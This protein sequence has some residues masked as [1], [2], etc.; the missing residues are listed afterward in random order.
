MTG[1]VPVRKEKAGSREASVITKDRRFGKNIA[2]AN[3]YM[4]IFK[5]MRGCIA[6][7]VFTHMHMHAHTGKR[8]PIHVFTPMHVY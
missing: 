8:I 6:V 2:D 4:P 3:V 7:Y 1:R 5:Y